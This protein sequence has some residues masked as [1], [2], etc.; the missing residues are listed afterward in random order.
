MT[1]IIDLKPGYSSFNNIEYVSKEHLAAIEKHYSQVTAITA[2]LAARQIWQLHQE[3][4]PN[5][6][7]DVIDAWKYAIDQTAADAMAYALNQIPFKT[8]KVGSEGAKEKEKMGK[9]AACVKGCYGKNGNP[10]KWG[11][12]DVVEGTT[13]AA[14]NLPG[15][16]SVLA[17]TDIEGIMPT[18][19][20]THYMVKL[21]APPQAEGILGIDHYTVEGLWE[22]CARLKIKPEQLTQI[23]M[24]P[25]KKG[26]EINQAY[27]DVARQAGVN[28]K[29]IDVGDF[30]PGVRA[31]LDPFKFKYKPV[32]L[33]GRGGF[34]E[35]ILAATAAKATGG[36]MQA[37][38]FDKDPSVMNNNPIMSLV[39]LVPGP[40]RS[41]A[42]MASFITADHE[43]FGQPGV[44]INKKGKYVVKTMKVT[45]K[46][47]NFQTDEIAF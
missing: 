26:R 4:G 34:E 23:T 19:E 32:I 30:M 2:V 40:A 21:I 15:A 38:Q 45:V 35:G 42:L 11:V 18:P 39:D 6:P 46:G 20:N 24:D 14:K 41:S 9:A 5:Q 31:A 27:V 12:S 8:K 16:S 25:G 1:Y 28:L 37:W 33:V 3:Y 43:W 22:L 29:L 10:E 13:L 17:I 7:K 44:K 36:F 47:V